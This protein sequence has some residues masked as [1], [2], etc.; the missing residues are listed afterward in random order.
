M[1][2]TLQEV[3]LSCYDCKDCGLWLFR[4][5]VVFGEGSSNAKVMLI[6]EAPGADEDAQGRPFVGLSGQMLSKVMK[7][8]GMDRSKCYITNIVKCRPPQNR[9]PSPEEAVTCSRYLIS[10][11]FTIRPNYI[12]TI[13]KFSTE[14]LF[15]I[16]N[17]PFTTITSVHG[18]LIRLSVFGY[19]VH[20]FPTFHPSAGL[21]NKA[22][23][24]MLIKDLHK[25]AGMIKNLN[26]KKELRK[27]K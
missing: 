5:R 25:F 23:L 12:I 3:E 1:E 19:S 27:R 14:F 16:A 13:G 18:C 4:N 26:E 15:T 21:R 24:A 17:H 11:L 22:Y 7:D 20:V 6:G 8:A 2:S 10:Q 9:L